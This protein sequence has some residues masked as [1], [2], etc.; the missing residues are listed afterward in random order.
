M[1]YSECLPTRLNPLAERACFSPG[2]NLQ[3]FAQLRLH[4]DPDGD[5]N[6]TKKEFRDGFIK[7][8][9][10]GKFA[11]DVPCVLGRPIGPAHTLRE[12][13]EALQVQYHIARPLAPPYGLRTVLL[14]VGSYNGAA[15]QAEVNRSVRT[16][17]AT[18]TQGAFTLGSHL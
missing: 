10:E 6:I 1:A 7:G 16:R 11:S 9:V 13:W 14:K 15:V 4:F 17:A 3:I 5:G 18:P 12:A 8:V 2:K